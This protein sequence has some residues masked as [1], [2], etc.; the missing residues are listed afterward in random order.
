MKFTATFEIGLLKVATKGG[1]FTDGFEIVARGN[2]CVLRK[3]INILSPLRKN[4]RKGDFYVKAA[5][6]LRID[7]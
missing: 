3:N 5:A 6:K 1:N 2:A 7:R 4:F